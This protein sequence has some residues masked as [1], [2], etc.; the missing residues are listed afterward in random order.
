MKFDF[1][2][3]DDVMVV[4]FEGDL[5]GEEN[6]PEIIESVTEVIEKG[7]VKCAI[8]IANV[9][10]INSS[11]IGVLITLLTKFRN[12]EG[13][14]VLVNPSDQVKKLLIITKLNNIFHIEDNLE[15]ANQILNK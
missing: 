5:I 9:R 10:Y 2:I 15:A 6:G 13:E 3:N 4:T 11:G 8:D 1:E 12:K 7:V 14:V